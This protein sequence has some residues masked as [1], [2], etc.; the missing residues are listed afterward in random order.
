MELAR[1]PKKQSGGRHPLG[2]RTRANGYKA[3]SGWS[4]SKV[5]D[6]DPLALAKFREEQERDRAIRKAIKGKQKQVF[7]APVVDRSR[8]HVSTV[9][10][11]GFIR[12]E[13][14]PPHSVLVG[15]WSPNGPNLFLI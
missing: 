13:R 10:A 9:L 12:A 14:F 4:K 11:L 6:L 15:V 2:S 8:N 3:A 1:N 5:T 7:G